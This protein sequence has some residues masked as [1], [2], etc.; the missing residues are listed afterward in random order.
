M[1]IVDQFRSDNYRAIARQLRWLAFE[2]VP[3]DLCR[4]KQLLALAAGF[5]DFA[6][7]IEPTNEKIAAD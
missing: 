5:D 7:R 2:K 4:R 6:D 1:L 3:F